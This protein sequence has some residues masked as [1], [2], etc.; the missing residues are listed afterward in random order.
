[1]A[2]SKLAPQTAAVTPDP[3]RPAA[4]NRLDNAL[5]AIRQAGSKALIAYLTAGDPDPEASLQLLQ[6]LVAGGADVVEIGLPFSDPLA[7]GPVIQAAS[8]RAL[9]AGTRVRDVF[10]L[11]RRLRASSDAASRVPIAL[12][13][14][15]NPILRLG[16]GQFLKEAAAAG[17]DALV[18]PDLP[19]EEAGALLGPLP[20]GLAVV[21]FAA[22]TSTDER[23]R[24]LAGQSSGFVYCVAVTGVTGMRQSVSGD[25]RGLVERVRQYT[26]LPVAVGF[27]IST[28]E[29]A[30]EVA[31]VAD[32]VI[33]G[34]ALV[35]QVAVALRDG[36]MGEAAAGIRSLVSQ[37]KQAIAC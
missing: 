9:A 19:P 31:Q 18:I 5:A 10:A 4:P 21:P 1:M 15:A 20:A 27:G 22:P 14:Y 11:A 28:P 30:R 24:L 26:D 2:D 8:T 13:T 16:P 12:L 25:V 37:I 23:L 35:D 36:R 6:A 3:A 7:D 32:A 17:I 29:Q 34:S 33:V